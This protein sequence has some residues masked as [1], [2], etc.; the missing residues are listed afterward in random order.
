MNTYL[1][2]LFS[3]PV[4]QNLLPE[5]EQAILETGDE[6]GIRFPKNGPSDSVT[7]KIRTIY[8]VSRMFICGFPALQ[9]W[10]DRE[11]LH[12]ERIKIGPVES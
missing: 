12:I 8:C 7:F 11:G 4:P 5:V 3:G 6:H 9:W 1:S 2:R 10:V